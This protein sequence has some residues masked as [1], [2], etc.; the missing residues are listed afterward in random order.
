[1][2]IFWRL[3]RGEFKMMK[4]SIV[5]VTLNSSRYLDETIRSVLSQDYP[6]FEYIIIDGGS[7]DGTLD[8]IMGHA[9]MDSR[10]RWISE[11][12]GGISDAMNKG[13][14]LATGD[15]IAH[16]H[17]DDYYAGSDVFSC[18][19]AAFGKNPKALWLTGGEYVVDKQGEIL[20]EIKVRRYSY[21]KLVRCNFILHPA[22][23]VRSDGL[24]RAGLFDTGRRYAMDY[25]LWL[26]LG[27]LGAPVAVDRPLACFRLH[28]GSVS[29]AQTERAFAEALEIRRELMKG[30][31]VRFFFHYLYYMLKRGRNSRLTRR[32]S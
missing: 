3:L 25:D 24:R 12:D 17:S 31:P 29:T 16:I 23:F 8:I 21:R 20:Q 22:T 10:V 15:V 11:P 9:A 13:I 2:G 5:T 28:E 1:M 19:A 30:K 4:F 26:R 32:L 14:R 27:A 6:D 18:V 7:T